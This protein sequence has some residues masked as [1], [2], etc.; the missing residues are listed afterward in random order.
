MD[1]RYF[2]ELY[3]WLKGDGYAIVSEYLYTY[4]IPDEFNPAK[5]CQRAP[6]TSSTDE[7]IAESLG[8]IEQEILETI[9]AGAT[10]GFL[11]GW[12]S[13]IQLDKLLRDAGRRIPRN[14]R[15]EIMSAIGYELH[16]GLSDGRV[17]NPVM[18][19]GGKPRLYVK[20]DHPAYH[21]VGPSAIAAAY[22][23]AQM[24]GLGTPVPQH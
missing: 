22:V 5:N 15:G 8:S 10:P 18:P 12:V 6:I 1:G 20:R 7:A 3:D 23:S 14:K 4:P 16:P 9:A 13:S 17:N 21:L 24:P 2:S 11:G 19:D